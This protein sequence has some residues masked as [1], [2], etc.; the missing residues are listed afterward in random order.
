MNRPELRPYQT[1]AISN[2][3]ASI[4]SGVR[5]L[6]LQAAT[7]AGKTMTA[8][9]IIRCCES[10]G[11]RTL[12][13]CD[14]L[15]LVEQAL[16]AF[17][18]YGLDV[19]VMQAQHIRTDESR[20]TQVCTA[21]T[22]DRRIKSQRYEFE[23]YPVHLICCDEAHVQHKVR[24]E[25]AV[26]Y[27][28]AVIL[29]L[30][31]TPF[32]KGLGTFYQTVVSAISMKQLISEGYLSTYRAFAPFVP[33]MKG[34]KQTAGDWTKDASAEVYDSQIIGDMVSHWKRHA[35]DRPTLAFGCNV[36]H[37]KAIA[38]EF[39]SHGIAAAHV[40]GYG[41]DADKL[42]RER[43][44]E[45]YKSGDI[46]LL[47]SV[48]MLTRGF[49]A[50]L[51]S[52]LIIA[53]PTKSL[54]MHL[55]IVGRGLRT[56]AGKDDCVILD[57]AGNFVRHGFPEDITDFTLDLGVKGESKDK[58]DKGEKLPVPCP[59]C[60]TL[61]TSHKCPACGFAPEK[62]NEIVNVDGE[63]VELSKVEA[64]KP[65][66]FTKEQKQQFYSELLTYAEKRGYKH[67]WAANT[68][69]KR[70]EVWPVGLVE[71]KRQVSETTDKYCTSLMIRYAKGK[72][73]A[74]A[75]AA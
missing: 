71:E 2:L 23:Q 13:V 14:S 7:G 61:K 30:T 47:S 45:R 26:L 66:Q 33:D 62:Q 36:A 18:N 17:D 50:P 54:S 42:E 59:S 57:H 5:R 39:A 52:C 4:A 15:E 53:R 40:D 8:A 11:K 72:G 63:L 35:H 65:K 28:N 25:L 38:A 55:Q 49:D 37:S 48:S 1:Q 44:I 3:R 6:I 75:N 27:P 22:L 10:K 68:Y 69:R 16:S 64:A 74:E 60:Q 31:A 24:D 41:N 19:G 32:S 43:T 21:Q 51:T 34:V 56:F 70:F 12:F 9:E 29:G 20:L 46:Q 67:G 58:R 73:K